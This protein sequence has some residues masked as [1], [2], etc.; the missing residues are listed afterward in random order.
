MKIRF[1]EPAN[2]PYKKSLK[3]HF[4]YDE[5]IRTPSNGIITL[6]TILKPI[7]GDVFCY[8]ESISE[9]KWNDVFDADIIFISIFTF[10][11]NRGYKLARYIRRHSK[12]LIVFGGLHATLNYKET[13]KYCDYVLRGEGDELIVEFTKSISSG[14]AVTSPGIAYIRNGKLISTGEPKI[15]EKIDTIPDRNLLYGFKKATKYNT[16]WPQVHASRGCPHNC[17]YCA[18]VAAFGR[19]VRTRSPENVVDDIE[20]TIKFFSGSRRLA[21]ML[22]ITDDN[23]FADRN[24]KQKNKI[25]LYYSGTI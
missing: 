5:N 25:F 21:N 12:A 4:V 7:Y 19:K 15:P 17:D 8:S 14:K 3:N 22:W 24:N 11:A 9:I 16:V 13:A 1:I 23:F 2:T 18:L 6:A 10:N 20:Q